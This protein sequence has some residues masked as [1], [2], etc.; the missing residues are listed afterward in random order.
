MASALAYP[1]G[2]ALL[3][4]I[5]QAG[6]PLRTRLALIEY[7]HCLL[8]AQAAGRSTT[9]AL[10]T[11]QARIDRLGEDIDDLWDAYE[12]ALDSD[13][14]VFEKR[15][16]FQ[17]G[18]HALLRETATICEHGKFLDTRYM[19]AAGMTSPAQARAAARQDGRT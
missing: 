19:K 2:D 11:L 14:F 4:L 9:A 10:E 15:R 13:S 12:P 3:A 16:N 8:H 1:T 17:R 5:Y 6:A 7:I 18:L